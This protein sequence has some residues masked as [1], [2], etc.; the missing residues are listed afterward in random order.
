MVGA[1][2]LP[3]APRCKIAL[4]NMHM[5]PFR[6]RVVHFE[7]AVEEQWEAGF[8]EGVANRMSSAS[9]L[10]ATWGASIFSLIVV[11]HAASSGAVLPDYL[12]AGWLG[13]LGFTSLWFWFLTRLLSKLDPTSY[14]QVRVV[15]LSAAAVLISMMVGNQLLYWGP[16]LNWEYS[17]MAATLIAGELGWQFSIVLLIFGVTVRPRYRVQRD[18]A[19]MTCAAYVIVICFLFGHV[20]RP[21]TIVGR[22][23]VLVL[24]SL[25]VLLGAFN[26]ECIDRQQWKACLQLGNQRAA[27]TAAEARCDAE[28]NLMA[29]LC[30]EVPSNLIWRFAQHHLTLGFQQI[31]NPSNGICGCLVLCTKICICCRL[32]TDLYF[33]LRPF[34][35][36]FS[37]W[38]AQMLQHGAQLPSGAL[39]TSL[40]CW[41]LHWTRVSWNKESWC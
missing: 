41:T 14:C 35:N 21:S 33:F 1:E 12:A 31:R 20:L 30:H 15:F 23:C 36:K 3:P 25:L 19:I 7:P 22:C 27:T 2:E 13:I 9:R 4:C 34:R 24:C 8:V 18:V 28:R 26:A 16:L 39:S 5:N 6:V 29:F 40:T 17:E 37:W 11:A 38:L 10:I 32:S